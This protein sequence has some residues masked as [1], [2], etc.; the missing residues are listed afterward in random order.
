MF[1]NFNRD[2]MYETPKHQKYPRNPLYEMK[3]PETH[4]T[5]HQTSQAVKEDKVLDDISGQVTHL[6]QTAELVSINLDQ[7]NEDLKDLNDSVDSSQQ[8][9]NIT[10]SKV[11]RLLEKYKSYCLSR[12]FL[13]IVF[14]VLIVII[15]LIV[16]FW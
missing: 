2:R 10:N 6:S 11:T 4:E 15:L 12:Q 5:T 16:I 13:L 3:Y 14:L 8:D 1:F 7:D 9:M